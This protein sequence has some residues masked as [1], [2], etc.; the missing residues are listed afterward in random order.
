MGVVPDGSKNSFRICFAVFANARSLSATL[1]DHYSASPAALS[2]HCTLQA[3][4]MQTRPRVGLVGRPSVRS[5]AVADYLGSP[6]VHLRPAAAVDTEAVLRQIELAESDLKFG[7]PGAEEALRSRSYEAVLRSMPEDL[8]LHYKV[9]ELLLAMNRRDEAMASS[10]RACRRS[11]CSPTKAAYHACLVSSAELHRCHGPDGSCSAHRQRWPQRKATTNGSAAVLATAEEAAATHIAE[12]EQ[13]EPPAELP[14]GSSFCGFNPTMVVGG[15]GERRHSRARC[16]AAGLAHGVGAM[17]VG[18]W[19]VPAD[20]DAELPPTSRRSLRGAVGSAGGRSL[21]GFLRMQLAP[22]ASV[23]VEA[24]QWLRL[25]PP[26]SLCGSCAARPEPDSALCRAQVSLG[27][28]YRGQKRRRKFRPP[29]VRGLLLLLGLV[30]LLIERCDVPQ[31]S[32][33]EWPFLYAGFEDSRAL[34]HGSDVY[35]FSNH[36]DCH[37]GRRVVVSRLRQTEGGQLEQAAAW[38]LSLEDG[39]PLRPTEKN[40]SPFVHAGELHL[41][42]SLEPH[43]VLRCGW[44]GGGCAVAHNTSSPFLQTYRAL[45][46]ELRGGPPQR[47]AKTCQHCREHERGMI[48]AGGS[49]YAELRDGRRLAAA[50]VKD[51]AHEPALYGTV[52]YLLEAEPPFRIVSLSPKLCISD[53]EVEIAISARC[54]LQYVTGLVVNEAT[55]AA[56]VSFGEL[57][58]RMKGAFLPLDRLLA[59]AETHRLE[60]DEHGDETTSSECAAEGVGLGGGGS[61]HGLYSRA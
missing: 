12:F 38:Q 22:D 34:A 18:E 54:A 57:D 39:M 9:W 7:R 16:G 59:L 52:F 49:P 41:S 44:S 10:G 31:R 4:P 43:V 58:V 3:L 11:T 42:Y 14:E 48:A 35:L 23:G 33:S 37:G 2:D 8:A 29:V 45:G 19:L 36:E 32:C 6:W 5:T 60:S 56:L 25:E 51:D 27:Q 15:G 1:S 28:L 40:W 53:R 24:A 46:Q 17:A 13:P 50:H 30:L 47:L 26:E 61:D 55:N 20:S 21:V